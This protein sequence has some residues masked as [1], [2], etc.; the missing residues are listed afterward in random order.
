MKI[1][2]KYTYFSGGTIMSTIR[3]VAEYAH[4]S[5]ATVSRVLK[6]TGPVSPETEQRVYEAIEKLSYLPPHSSKKKTTDK[7]LSIL[8][9]FP[10]AIK[11]E[12]LRSI[13]VA[14][15]AIAICFSISLLGLTTITTKLYGYDGY[16][17]LIVV[18]LPA[19]I[20]GIPKVKKLEAEL[21]AQGK[22]I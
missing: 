9:L 3:D 1:I 4:V 16:Y 6:K 18:I 21:K 11:S 20:W 10:N 8:V 12:K 7:K 13:I 5:I 22:E 2:L 14:G 19:L 15:V 17:S